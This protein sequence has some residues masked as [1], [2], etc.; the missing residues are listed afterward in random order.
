MKQLVA[1]VLAVLATRHATAA[2]QLTPV[3]SGL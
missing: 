3:V 2:L 1:V